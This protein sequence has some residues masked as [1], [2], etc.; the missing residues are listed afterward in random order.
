MQDI[1]AGRRA[2]GNRATE[3]LNY[4]PEMTVNGRAGTRT[5]VPLLLSSI[6]YASVQPFSGTKNPVLWGR[7]E[8]LYS[9]LQHFPELFTWTVT[10]FFEV[11]QHQNSI[12]LLLRTC[13]IKSLNLTIKQHPFKRV[14]IC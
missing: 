6:F 2:V 14:Y 9:V 5:Q 1:L 12:L 7:E 10:I 8:K 3:N 13:C 11:I 4:I